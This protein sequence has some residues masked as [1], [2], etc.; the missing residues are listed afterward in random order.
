M[1]KLALDHPQWI[2]YVISSAIL[3]LLVLVE[4]SYSLAAGRR[5]YDFRDSACNLAMYAGSFAI[6]LFWINAVFSLYAGVHRHSLFRLGRQWWLFEGD[7]RPWEWIALFL[8]EDLTFY[9]FHRFSHR[10]RIL[11][12]SHVNHHSSERFNLTTAIRQTWTPFLAVVFWLPLA[13][14]GFD[15]LMILTAQSLSLIYQSWLHTELIPRLGPL[16][17]IFNT[18][19]HHRVHHGSDTQYTDKNFGGVLIIWDRLFGTFQEQ[20]GPIAYGLHEKLGS[21]NPLV[22]AFHEWAALLKI[23]RSAA[24]AMLSLALC[25]SPTG[26]EAGVRKYYENRLLDHLGALHGYRGTFSESGVLQTGEKLVSEVAFS[27]PD[28]YFEKVLSPERLKGDVIASSGSRLVLY[29]PKTHYAIEFIHLKPLTQAE[30]ET[31]IKDQFNSNLDRYRYEVEGKSEVAGQPAISSSFESR[32]GNSWVGSGDIQVYDELS[33]PLGMKMLFKSGGKYE[34]RYESIAFNPE[35][36]QSAFDFMIPKDA[37]VSRW[38]LNAKSYTPE[39]ASAE[40]GAKFRLPTQLP[41]QLRLHKLIR[42]A[43]PVPAFTALYEKRPYFLNLTLFKDYGTSLVPAGFGLRLKDKKGG[44]LILGPRSSTYSFVSA[45]MQYVAS[46]N[47]PLEE[48]LDV[49]EGF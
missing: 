21:Y 29:Y 36:P 26:C 3:L 2:L 32:S 14:L 48:F 7:T 17:W 38:D 6:N 42:Q 15:P 5:L 19:A 46:G 34:Y 37:I 13:W 8:L 39:Q 18:P 27:N 12:A 44:D 43:G 16:E 11:W 31:L 35:I 40:L 24:L 47:L 45:G 22:V 10:L 41:R 28:S 20:R 30:Q 4:A 33:F 23:R 49:V 1:L 25:L 9:C